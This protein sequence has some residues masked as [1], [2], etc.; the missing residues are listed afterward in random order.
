ML[1]NPFLRL[2]F[3]LSF[4]PLTYHLIKFSFRQA[5]RISPKGSDD[6]IIYLHLNTFFQQ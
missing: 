5:V 2:F 6:R 4:L 1:N 3:K